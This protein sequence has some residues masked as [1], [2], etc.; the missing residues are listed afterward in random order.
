VVTTIINVLVIMLGIIVLA[1]FFGQYIAI[2]IFHIKLHCEKIARK[3]RV[4]VSILRRDY[5]KS[6]K[7][8][9]DCSSTDASEKMKKY[10]YD[11]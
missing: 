5:I 9:T 11:N 8:R 2:S 1:T 4:S 10:A 3:I 6:N 7:Q